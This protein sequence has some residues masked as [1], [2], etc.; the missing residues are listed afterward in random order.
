M[1]RPHES[2]REAVLS[3]IIIIILFVIV[4]F[5]YSHADGADLSTYSDI[6][7]AVYDRIPADSNSNRWTTAIVLRYVNIAKRSIEVWSKANE[8][9]AFIALN[10]DTILYSLPDDCDID[11][12]KSV[13]HYNSYTGQIEAVTKRPLNEFGKAKDAAPLSMWASVGD[14]L[15]VYKRPDTEDSLFV[16]YYKITGDM[17]GDTATVDIP[18]VYRNLIVDLAVAYIR[19]IQVGANGQWFQTECERIKNE[20]SQIKGE[21]DAVI[22]PYGLKEDGG[23]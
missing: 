9:V 7:S 4:A 18:K 16:H 10:P 5:I 22:Q 11:G 8:E 3:V 15:A 13:M 2:Y 20:I 19:D 17:V 23:Q 6:K 21:P 1:I 12:I 14:S